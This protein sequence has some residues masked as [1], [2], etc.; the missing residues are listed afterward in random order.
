MMKFLFKGV[1][2][3]RARSLFPLLTV[4]FGVMLTVF[5]YGW[6]GGAK[7][8]FVEASAR[9]GSGHLI[10]MSRA[11]AE[12]ADQVPNDLAYIGVEALVQDL[13]TD[14]PDLNWTPRIRF[15]GLLDIPDENGETRVQGPV[16]GMA[17]DL[18]SEQ[19]PEWDILNLEDAVV[20]GRLPEKSGEILIS[21]E[22]SNRL[23]I[24]VGETATLISVTMNGSMAVANFTISGTLRF[25][26]SAMDR[27][28]I[29]A[30]LSDVQNALD[31]QDAAGEILGY[32]QDFVYRDVIANEI[33][34]K[35][36][37]MR[38]DESDEFSPVMNT[39]YN[40]SGLSELI[41]M[42]EIFPRVILGIFMAVM[43]I[44][45]WNAGLIGSL[46]RYGE[47]GVRLAMGENKGHLYRSMISE[48]LMIGFF[49]SLLGTIF[50]LA[51]CYYFQAHGFDFS[52]MMKNSSLLISD[53]FR[54]KVTP[55][56]YGIGFI[57]GMLATLLGT[58]ISG[59]GIYRRQTANLIKELEV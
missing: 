56:S 41:A 15:G 36:N 18:F 55:T 22:F 29:I 40:Q 4:F 11:F 16:M 28:A 1:I 49:G 25:G 27:G 26:V 45:L 23:N 30:D 33:M 2:R 54:T 3:D 17:L 8:N 24:S 5:L 37:T 48:S 6:I 53:V 21:D 34:V 9:F 14:F 19:S 52:Y 50:G 12:D 42:M 46:R 32:F 57:P 58:M 13:K 35:F 39:L 43:S 47:I 31:M 59:I 20:K 10:I 44:V 51:I 7:S 38:S